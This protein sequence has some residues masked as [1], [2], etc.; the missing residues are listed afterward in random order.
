MEDM[1]HKSTMPVEGLTALWDAHQPE[2][3]MT[4][5]ME[6]ELGCLVR[7]W[8]TLHAQTTRTQEGKSNINQMLFVEPGIVVDTNPLV[9]SK[10][11]APEGES[12]NKVGALMSICAH[13]AVAKAMKRE[14]PLDAGVGAFTVVTTMMHPTTTPSSTLTTW[15]VPERAKWVLITQLHGSVSFG[16]TSKRKPKESDA[17]RGSGTC[18]LL[19]SDAIFFLQT[20]LTE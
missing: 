20:V 6:A 10:T 13:T 2:Q 12:G 18:I 7:M 11:V 8:G 14:N 3:P 5:Q 4:L 1:E 9:F 16:I 15:A 17:V 19:P